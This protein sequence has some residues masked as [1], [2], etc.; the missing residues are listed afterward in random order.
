M[1]DVHAHLERMLASDVGRHILQLVRVLNSALG[2]VVQ[3][4]HR[5]EVLNRGGRGLRIVFGKIQVAS[6]VS[7][8][9]FRNESAAEIARVADGVIL[10]EDSLRSSPEMAEPEI[11]H[12]IR[13]VPLIKLI[14]IAQII[15]IRELVIDAYQVVSK[16]KRICQ[17]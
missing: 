11:T 7:K 6:H 3:P 12:H 9:R 1:A 4:A 10:P 17:R 13:L 16:I 8:P 15:V 2:K 5:E 14:P